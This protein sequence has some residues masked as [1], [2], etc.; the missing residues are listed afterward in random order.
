MSFPKLKSTAWLLMLAAFMLNGAANA[1]PK[2]VA[3][4][5]PIHSLVAAVMDGVAEPEL[6]MQSSASPHHYRLKPSQRRA[7]SEAEL[8]V[9][10]GPT[11][12]SFIPRLLSGLDPN[13]RSLALM[14]IKGLVR[15]PQRQKH[16]RQAQEQAHSDHDAASAIDPHIWLST[17]NAAAMVKAITDQLSRIDPEHSEYYQRNQNTVQQRISALQQQLKLPPKGQHQAFFSYHDAYQY[18]ENEFDLDNA[19]FV[20]LDEETQASALRIKQV[21]DRLIQQQIG[22][23]VY[24]APTQPKIIDAIIAGTQARAIELDPNG[25]LLKPGGNAWFE[26]MTALGKGFK[27]CIATD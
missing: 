27:S 1:A 9:W 4:L 5:K 17:Q 24:A 18:F 14:D 12:E 2:V 20:T 11:L 13:T 19:G 25:V 6:L 21:R 15:L 10:V 3:T 7:L 26:I 8:I 16:G 22:C 23:V